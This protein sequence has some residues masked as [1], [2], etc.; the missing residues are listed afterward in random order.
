M[1]ENKYQCNSYNP[2]NSLDGKKNYKKVFRVEKDGSIVERVFL[3][4]KDKNHRENLIFKHYLR[5]LTRFFIKQ[6]VGVNILERDKPWDFKCEL[7]NGLCFNVEITSISDNR[8]QFEINNR[9]EKLSKWRNKPAIPL[10]QLIKLNY[11]FPN[12]E[13]DE[14]INIYKSQSNTKSDNV[15]NPFYGNELNILLSRLPEPS[16]SLKNIISDVISKKLNKNHPEKNKTILII[17]N[18]TSAFDTCDYFNVIESLEHFIDSA[19]FPE[20][21][22]YTGYYSDEDGSNAEFSFSP[23]KVTNEQS[24]IL[25][26]IKDSA[27][28]NNFF[29]W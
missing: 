11:L 14:I 6:D 15:K 8:E 9:E 27:H 29:L 10:N 23:L 22:F 16:L 28:K 1:L 18:R 24:K 21:W 5:H 7:S 20:I 26:E 13:I 4:I 3:D 12:R 25:D 17:D 2:I 19:P